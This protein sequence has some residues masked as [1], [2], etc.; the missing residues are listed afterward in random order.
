[1]GA[2]VV[3]CD[4][5]SYLIRARALQNLRANI[6][7]SER[8][9][10]VFDL[11]AAVVGSIPTPSGIGNT[12]SAHAQPRASRS[13]Y[14]FANLDRFTPLRGADDVSYFVTGRGGLHQRQPILARQVDRWVTEFHTSHCADRT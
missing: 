13:K 3:C 5:G 12:A 10:E 14:V 8:G 6:S 4:S 9:G 2:G 1:V 11:S 7:R